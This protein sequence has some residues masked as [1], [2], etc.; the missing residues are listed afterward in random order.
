MRPLLDAEARARPGRVAREVSGQ[1]SFRNTG[2]AE[3]PCAY[4]LTM[5][6][7]MAS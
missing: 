2:A 3:M 6:S 1:A 4:G 5:R 7:A